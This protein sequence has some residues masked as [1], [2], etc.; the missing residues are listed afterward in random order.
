MNFKYKLSRRLALS[1]ILCA[2]ATS[3][4][5]ACTVVDIANPAADLSKIVT[6]PT[7]VTLLPNAS[8]LFLAYGITT[9]GDSTSVQVTWS[10]SGS[11]I[12]PSGQ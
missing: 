3:T 7:T 11:T 2:L 12:T 10:A 1:R 5:V 8:Q 4:I 6:L 9:A